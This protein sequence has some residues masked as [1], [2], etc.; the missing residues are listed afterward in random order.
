MQKH[1]RL[2]SLL[3]AG[4]LTLNAAGCSVSEN[5][6]KSRVSGLEESED[7]KDESADD[8]KSD[9][10]KT[11]EDLRPQDNFYDYVNFDTL[12]ELEI[13]YGESGVSGFGEKESNDVLEDFIKEIVNSDEKY[14]DGSNRKIIRD[15]FNQYMDYQ[16]TSAVD[17]EIMGN[18]RRILAAE[19]TDELFKIWGELHREY[20]LDSVFQFQIGRDYRD[21]SKHCI[22]ISP[23]NTFFDTELK[24]IKELSSNCESANIIARDMLRVMGDDYE[25][26]NEKAKQ[27][28]YLGINIANATNTDDI[29]QFKLLLETEKTSFEE[30]DSIVSNLDTS[31]IELFVG[32]GVE[33][34]TDGIYIYDKEQLRAINDLITEENLEKWKTYVFALYLYNNGDLIRESNDILGDY[35]PVSKEAKDKIAIGIVQMFLQD[36]LSE[37]YA[38]RFYTPE[39]DKAMNKMFDKIIGSYDELIRKADW[40]TSGTRDAL[41]KK[42][43]NIHLITAPKPSEKTKKDTDIIGSNFVESCKKINIRANEKSIETLRRKVDRDDVDMSAMT[44]N[45]QYLPCN[46]INV[47]VAIMQKPMFDPKASDAENLGRLGTV[48][49][50][51][52]GHAFDS[53][54]I[55]FN[56][57]GILDP[58]WINETDRKVLE[59]R[60]DKLADYYSKFTVME[61]YHVKGEKTN[62]ENYADLGALE[63][64]TNI[65]D[66]KEQLKVLFENY[67][68]IWCS[69][70]V[71]TDGILALNYDEHSPGSVRVNAVLASNEKF[72]EV[73]DVKEGDGMYFPPEER[74]SRW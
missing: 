15:F 9:K 54:C 46:S 13:P 74:V 25:T 16:E 61:V 35:N 45:A 53:N 52:I 66:D 38:E 37:E 67:A 1:L 73:Y 47:T 48:M 39:L 64:V 26:A 60:A 23:V 17:D 34:A 50:H 51:E 18:C 42:L 65:I 43:H 27:M 30:F 7:K 55:K 10:K 4:M 70:M 68:Q 57:E 58:D 56:P 14:A 2:V 5:S 44:V 71:D 31:A 21:G 36:Q 32:D 24:D 63:C 69:L 19:D 28:V 12:N 29:D 59:E 49:A 11:K 33:N 62:G 6:G 20:G 22:S 8:E 40:L 72:I 3:L 41:L